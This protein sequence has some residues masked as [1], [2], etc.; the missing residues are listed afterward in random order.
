[1]RPT[2]RASLPRAVEKAC[3]PG[4]GLLMGDRR[5]TLLELPFHVIIDVVAFLT[6]TSDSQLNPLFL[7]LIFRSIAPPRIHQFVP[8]FV[9]CI[10]DVTSGGSV[11]T[12]TADVFQIWRLLFVDK[13]RLTVE[14]DRVADNALGIVLAIGRVLRLH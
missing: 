14:A 7:F 1:M 12:L 2:R 4:L 8:F 13:S 9:L 3:S 10:F 6:K 5:P 11:T